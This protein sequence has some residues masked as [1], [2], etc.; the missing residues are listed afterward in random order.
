MSIPRLLTMPCS[1]PSRPESRQTPP[2]TSRSPTPA[3]R[4][5]P[6]SGPSAQ[7]TR[8][9]LRALPATFMPT[10][11]CPL[12]TT[13]A[14]V[15]SKNMAPGM[16][17]SCWKLPWFNW[18]CMSHIWFLHVPTHSLASLPSPQPRCPQPAPSLPGSPPGLRIPHT[19]KP[20]LRRCLPALLFLRS[21]QHLRLGRELCPGRT[22][23]PRARVVKR[24]GEAQRAGVLL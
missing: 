2:Q 5:P 21:A 15:G 3:N 9:F 18:A 17:V 16:C 11:L 24:T 23:L 22:F 14:Q 8:R 13:P 10:C 12:L 19:P 6:G 20:A 4:S 7:G 1:L